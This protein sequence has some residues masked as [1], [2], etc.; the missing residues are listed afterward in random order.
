MWRKLERS[1]KVLICDQEPTEVASNRA[2]LPEYSAEVLRVKKPHSQG[3][4]P[5]VLFA[6]FACE[7]SKRRDGPHVSR[8]MRFRH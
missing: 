6:P 1:G 8:S 3:L 2:L 7:T 5:L 4:L